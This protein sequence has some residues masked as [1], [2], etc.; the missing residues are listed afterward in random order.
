MY[1][2]CHKSGYYIKECRKAATPNEKCTGRKGKALIEAMSAE[3]NLETSSDAWHM[4]SGAT[5]HMLNRR[6]WF[7][8][9]KNSIQ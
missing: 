2:Y 7:C 9:I 6:E 4:D 5:E 3:Y 8:H 1:V